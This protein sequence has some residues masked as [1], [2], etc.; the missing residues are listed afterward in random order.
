MAMDTFLGRANPRRTLVSARLGA[1]G[2]AFRLRASKGSPSGFNA[3]YAPDRYRILVG[4]RH[5]GQ[6]KLLA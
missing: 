1:A 6:P 5:D 2:Y 4:A 3:R